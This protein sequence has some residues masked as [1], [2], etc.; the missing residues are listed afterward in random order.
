MKV[1][2]KLTAAI[3]AM[4]NVTGL[5]LGLAVIA[6]GVLNVQVAILAITALTGLGGYHIARQAQI[7]DR[8]K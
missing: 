4:L 6:P 8:E 1:S 2:R 5:T 7:D 3:L